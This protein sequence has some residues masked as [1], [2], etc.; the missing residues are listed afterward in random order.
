MTSQSPSAIPKRSG[1]A[2]RDTADPE[3]VIAVVVVIAALIVIIVSVL[4]LYRRRRRHTRNMNQEL[5]TIVTAEQA[6][7][8]QLPE[9]RPPDQ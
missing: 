5:T 3:L 9:E 4:I 8:E 7:D 2:T 1:S 6:P